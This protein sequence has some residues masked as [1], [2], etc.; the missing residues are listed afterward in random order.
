[1]QESIKNPHRRMITMLLATLALAGW[2]TPRA[3]D[4]QGRSGDY[5]LTGEV[6]Q[7]KV[8]WNFLRLGTITVRTLRDTASPDPSLFRLVMIVESNPDLG[9]VDIREFNESIVRASNLMS[10]RFRGKHRYGDNVTEMTFSYDTAHRSAA[11]FERDCRTGGILV[12]DTLHD[13]PPYVEGASLLLYSRSLLHCGRVVRV[14][15]MVGGK[16]SSTTLDFTGSVEEVD[17]EGIEWPVRALKY[18]GEAEWDGGSSAGLSGSFTGWM[19][20]DGAAIP[21][22]AEMHVIVGSITIE[23]E[24][25]NRPG[26]TP[27]QAM[28]AASH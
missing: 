6:L 9:V 14:P 11:C 27:P 13:V 5:L 22:R 12:A 24:K 16:L 28:R 8:K 23:L 25:W 15:T 21:L 2:V 17:V 1:M 18:T 4:A 10:L 7:Y 3:S 19:S 20:D 26:W